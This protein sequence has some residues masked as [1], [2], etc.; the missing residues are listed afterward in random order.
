MGPRRAWCS[1]QSDEEFFRGN[2]F[3]SLACAG[4]KHRSGCIE[5]VPFYWCAIRTR[6]DEDCLRSCSCLDVCVICGHLAEGRY[7]ALVFYVAPG[8][9][10]SVHLHHSAIDVCDSVERRRGMAGNILSAGRSTKGTGLAKAFNR[11]M[12]REFAEFVEK[13]AESSLRPLRLFFADSAV[14][15]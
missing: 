8:Q 15:C 7:S 10:R 11:R 14:R 5:P 6:F 2:V 1:Q 3:S 4:G 13:P 12:C 9:H